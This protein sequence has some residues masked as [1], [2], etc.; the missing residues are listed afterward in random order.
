MSANLDIIPKVVIRLYERIALRPS[1][2]WPSDRVLQD[3]PGPANIPI[4][5]Q[6]MDRFDTVTGPSIPAAFPTEDAFGRF[7]DS[8]DATP[9][10]TD[11]R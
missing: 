4:E 5:L 2:P 11:G 8:L 1:E 7:F 9:R 6:P 3:P 10:N